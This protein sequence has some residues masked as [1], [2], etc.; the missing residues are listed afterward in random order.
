ML[1]RLGAIRL[2]DLDPQMIAE[3]RAELTTHG[4]RPASVRKVMVILQG[5]LERA[6]E[7]RR[8]PANP[9]RAVRKPTQRRERAVHP[10]APEQVERLRA[11]LLGRGLRRDAVLVSLLAYAGLRPGEALALTW[12]HVRERTILIDRG[13][14]SAS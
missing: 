6:V 4:L 14:R 10:L 9:C 12:G 11:H 8:I 13:S 2:R 5:V 1:P 3:L 7:W